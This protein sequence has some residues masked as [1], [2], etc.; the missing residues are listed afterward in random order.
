MCMYICG[1]FWR[2]FFELEFLRG[3]GFFVKLRIIDLKVFFYVKFGF[4]SGVVI[5]FEEFI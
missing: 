3:G 5:F 2:G 4:F 1:F